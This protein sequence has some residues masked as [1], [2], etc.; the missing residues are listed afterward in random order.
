MS[1]QSILKGTLVV[2]AVLAVFVALDAK[3]HERSVGKWALVTLLTG[4]VGVLA[5][6]LSGGDEEIPLDELVDQVELD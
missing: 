5:Y 6:V 1:K 3:R 2:H 4:L